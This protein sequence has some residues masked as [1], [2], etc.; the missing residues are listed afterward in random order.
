VVGE[1]VVATPE[2]GSIPPG[3]WLVERKKCI[4]VADQKLAGQDL[5]DAGVM[6][7][8]K[9]KETWAKVVREDATMVVPR[10]ENCILLGGH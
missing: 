6:L 7:I 10:Q 1:A 3:S 8:A 5:G 4:H 2:R 9:E